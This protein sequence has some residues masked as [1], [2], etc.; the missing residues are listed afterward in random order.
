MGYLWR[1]APDEDGI[2]QGRRLTQIVL[3][4]IRTGHPGDER[5]WQHATTPTLIHA[6]RMNQW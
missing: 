4:G 3:D 2:R 1:V 6:R 5:A